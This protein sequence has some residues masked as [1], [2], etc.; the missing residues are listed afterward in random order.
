MQRVEIRIKEGIDEHWSEWFDG[1]EIKHTEQNETVLSGCIADQAA[2]Y[3]LVIK[4]RDLNLSLVS[5]NVLPMPSPET[6]TERLP[7][8]SRGKDDTESS[9]RFEPHGPAEPVS[10]GPVV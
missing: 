4:L 10:H 8:S 3:G 1:L 6:A 5:L 2:L 9:C 7:D